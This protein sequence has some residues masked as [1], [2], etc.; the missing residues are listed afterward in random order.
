MWLLMVIKEMFKMIKKMVR[1]MFA[2]II[3]LSVGAS[4]YDKCMQIKM[5]KTNRIMAETIGT[6]RAQSARGKKS[7]QLLV[8]SHTPSTHCCERRKRCWCGIDSGGRLV[9]FRIESFHRCLDQCQYL[10]DGGRGRR[11][12]SF[13]TSPLMESRL[14]LLAPWVGASVWRVWSK[15][16][17]ACRKKIMGD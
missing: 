4:M 13:M 6:G 9:V 2:G 16:K 12:R 7:V 8:L 14:I 15:G 11:S 3:T 10:V 17:K 5:I 1:L